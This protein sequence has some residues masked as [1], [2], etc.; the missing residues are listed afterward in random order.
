MLWQTYDCISSYKV[1][2]LDPFGFPLWWTDA[3]IL[4]TLPLI[5]YAHVMIPKS[6]DQ[7]YEYAGSNL[8]DWMRVGNDGSVH[9]ASANYILGFMLVDFIIPYVIGGAKVH[10]SPMIF[11]HHVVVVIIMTVGQYY[12]ADTTVEKS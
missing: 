4:R 2:T 7:T 3:A 9:Y 8:K 12:Y 6:I 5:F 1:I 10:E 11:A